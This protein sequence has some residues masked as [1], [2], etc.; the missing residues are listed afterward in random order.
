[1]TANLESF[2]ALSSDFLVIELAQ[3]D[4]F[5]GFRQAARVLLAL[6]AEPHAVRWRFCQPFAFALA[7]QMPT[8]DLFAADEAGS[9]AG[10]ALT[11][12]ELDQ[13]PL[14]PTQPLRLGK[15]QLSTLRLACC[16]N[17]A[18]RFALCYRWLYRLQSDHR[19]RLDALDSDW[20]EIER[21]AKAAGREI[22]KMHAFVRFRPVPGSEADADGQP[23][24]IAWFEPEHHV[25]RVASGFFRR[26]FPNM[27]W[28]ILTPQCSV[29]W[30]LEQLLLAP[31][32]TADQAPGP[33]AG[34][35]LWLTYYRATFNP[36]RL[37][38]QAMQREMPRKYWKN[39]PEAALISELVA[40][41]RGRTQRMLQT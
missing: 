37:K 29:Y 34:E 27:R 13:L 2:S 38:E 23:M 10:R 31:G 22:H 25:L 21:L 3:P 19:L 18:G 20:R 7:R 6:H 9:V 35:Q 1:M 14:S 36:A 4:D 30:D 39:L 28:A 5:D 15:S 40:G 33:D 32:S 17:L 16:H 24:Q 41:A 12:D 8:Q 11:P 26:R